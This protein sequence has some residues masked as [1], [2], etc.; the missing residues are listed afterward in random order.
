[1]ATESQEQTATQEAL[2]PEAQDGASSDGAVAE[3][4]WQA[5]AQAAEAEKAA[6][7]QRV[8]TQQGRQ[9]PF[10]EFGSQL[11]SV[12]DEMEATRKI[13]G[14]ISQAV[15]SGETEA[16]PT[17]LA[18]HQ[19][20]AEQN[21]TAT[22]WA[23][24]HDNL[25]GQLENALKDENGDWQFDLRAAR[26]ARGTDGA[27][28]SDLEVLM[29][30]T[31]E[32]RKAAD[33]WVEGAPEGASTSVERRRVD[34]LIGALT[35][36]HQ[37]TIRQAR[38]KTVTETEKAKVAAARAAREGVLRDGDVADMGTG[39]SAAGGSSP[40]RGDAFKGYNEKRYTSKQM[41]GWGFL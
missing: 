9:R 10:D 15:V 16:L 38:S 32:L 17:Q 11:Q 7:E 20:Q 27:S 5:R 19:R 1:V 25:L 31:P 37:A 24:Q 36:T 12:R 41:R 2:A 28:L 29:L 8:R 39:P 3:I 4:D 33:L 34:L 6:L 18:E 30:E 21:R 26:N 35:E 23:Y 13:V 22:Q 14:S 40:G